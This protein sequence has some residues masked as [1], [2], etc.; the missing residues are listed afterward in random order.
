MSCTNVELNENVFEILKRHRK[1]SSKNFSV[2]VEQY[3]KE[4][5]G[6]TTYSTKKSISYEFHKRYNEVIREY[7]KMRGY[8]RFKDVFPEMILLSRNI[9][10]EHRIGDLIAN[11]FAKRYPRFCVVIS[12]QNR[13][14]ISSCRSDLSFKFKKYKKYHVWFVKFNHLE[15]FIAEFRKKVK[16]Q[17]YDRVEL[18]E[19]REKDFNESYYN[20]Q[21][22]Q[23]RKNLS[24]ALSMMPWKY[25]KKANLKHEQTIFLKEKMNAPKKSI[26]DCL[27]EAKSNSKKKY[28]LQ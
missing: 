10:F 23:E 12:C 27:L 19:F 20:I 21:Y 8:I 11:Y 9:Q 4:N 17:V 2:L 24:H 5:L 22:I 28:D 16:A 18:A 15:E 7:N 1:T 26:V 14:Y 6:V 13:A 3:N 25:Q